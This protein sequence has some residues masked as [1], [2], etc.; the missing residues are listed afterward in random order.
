M[1]TISPVSQGPRVPG[2]VVAPAG[3]L[4]PV[5]APSVDVDNLA[6][7]LHKSGNR[8]TLIIMITINQLTH[9]CNKECRSP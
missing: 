4:D 6:R 1:V 7:P 8:K 5:H 9:A 2:H 3:R